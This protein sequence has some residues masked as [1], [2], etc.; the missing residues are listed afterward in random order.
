MAALLFHAPNEIT[1]EQWLAAAKSWGRVNILEAWQR[2]FRELTSVCV[3]VMRLEHFIIA[4]DRRLDNANQI[5]DSF[6][7]R[8]ALSLCFYA[9]YLGVFFAAINIWIRPTVFCDETPH[10][11]H[12]LLKPSGFFTYHQG[13][14]FKNSTWRSLCVECFVR[15]SEETATFALYIID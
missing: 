4:P 9:H 2:G 13:L 7:L 10:T 3:A 11:Q 8:M 12:N 14:R 6:S 5:S 15:I 1:V